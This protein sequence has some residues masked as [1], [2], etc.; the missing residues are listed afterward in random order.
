MKTI[1]YYLLFGFSILTIQAQEDFD[2]KANQLVQECMDRAGIVGSASGVHRNGVVE[3]TNSS[4]F[5]SAD[6]KIPFTN[7]TITRM[8]SFAKPITAIAI[9]QLLEAGKLGLD[10][11]ISKYV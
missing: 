8:G 3:W 9:M 4:G 11:P 2:L 10:D 1:L 5:S 7:T 6:D